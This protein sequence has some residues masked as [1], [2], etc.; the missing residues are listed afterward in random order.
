MKGDDK[1]IELLNEVLTA[2]LTAI[3]QYFIH[4][5]MCENFGFS[6]L[7]TQIRQESIDEMKHAEIL[8]ERILYLDGM[9]NMSR[10]FEIKIGKQVEDMFKKDLAL[11]KDAID[12]LNRGIA[13]C[14]EKG[15]DGSKQLLENILADEE[16]HYDWIETQLSLIESVGTQNYLSRQVQ[17][18]GE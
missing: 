10:Y 7:Y 8:I 14:S 12:R 9:P 4:A 3:N 2:E 15:D 17:S 5:E 18:G 6:A 13:L 1:V 16:R 11:E